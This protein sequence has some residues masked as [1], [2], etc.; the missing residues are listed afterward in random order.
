[1]L[2]GL[3]LRVK[4]EKDL[5]GPNTSTPAIATGVQVIQVSGQLPVRPLDEGEYIATPSLICTSV[6]S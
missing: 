3:A 1:M 2:R 4:D 6:F 5:F